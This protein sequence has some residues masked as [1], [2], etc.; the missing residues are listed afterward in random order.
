MAAV[1]APMTG[2]LSEDK[3]FGTRALQDKQNNSGSENLGRLAVVTLLSLMVIK[4]K[5]DTT[6]KLHRNFKV[7]NFL[8]H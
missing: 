4:C 5:R 6:S 8:K 1:I 2:S 7:L 3:K